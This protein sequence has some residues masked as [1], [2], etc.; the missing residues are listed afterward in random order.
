MRVKF[1][2]AAVVL[3]ICTF[4][5][6]GIALAQNVTVG[7]GE[8]LT[9]KGFINV[10]LFAQDQKFSFGNGTNAAFPAPP[11]ASTDPWMLDGDVRNSRLTLAW[12]GPKLE[13]EW[14]LNGVMEMDFHGGFNGTGAFSD[15]QPTPRLRLAYLD[16]VKGKTTFRFGQAWT[17]LFGNVAQ[18]YSHVAFPLGYGGGGNIGWRF[19]G[20]FMYHDMT[21]EGS[22]VKSKLS[23]AIMSGSW[24]GPGDN[25]SSGSAG[26]ASFGP[27]LELRYDWEAKNWGV[28]V[29][30]HYDKK[31]LTGAGASQPDDSLD[32]TALEFGAKW[33]A[34]AF[35]LQGNIYQGTAIG[36]NF[37]NITQF[38]DITGW[39]GWMQA[40]YD[41]NKR[42]AGYFFYGTD[43]PDDK[44][45]LA[46]IGNAGRTKNT[47]YAA[48]IMYNL[49]RYGFAFEYLHDVLETGPASTE[50]AG[51]QI[52][53]S[54]IYKF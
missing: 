46:A 10:S 40:G 30:G 2:T 11:E 16:L 41:F 50:T 45:V 27:Q 19:P 6:P 33:R 12:G 7:D 3:A 4:L 36:N 14:K 5:V 42:W 29:V 48:S 37:G 44:D 21:G 35:S 31:D 38:G 52:S 47:M 22:A 18:S 49:S 17:P 32:G 15:E 24:S 54:F 53:T 51:N 9:I 25:L 23:A 13:N 39:G 28:Y 43:D 26:E 20:V 8:S 34:G 1:V